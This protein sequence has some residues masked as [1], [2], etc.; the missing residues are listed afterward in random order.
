MANAFLFP[1]QGSQFIGMGKKLAESIPEAR[2]VFEEVDAAL[3]ENLSSIIWSGEL[4][5]LT[6]TK[7]AQP[8]IMAVSIAVFRSLI[9]RGLNLD[10]ISVLAGHS[11]GEYSAFC[12]SGVFSLSDTAKILRKRGLAMQKA[13]PLGKGAM[14]AILGLTSSKVSDLLKQGGFDL[15]KVQIA[16]DNDPSQVVISGEKG[17][18]EQFSEFLKDNGARKIIALPVSAPFHSFLM[19]QAAIEMEST[20]EE[21]E[22]SNPKIPI[23]LNVN[24]QTLETKEGAQQSLINQVTGTVRWRESL[25]TMNE[26]KGVN[27]FYEIGPGKVLSGT[28]K[29]TLK[30][31]N[32]FSVYELED[33][34]RM[35]EVINV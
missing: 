10:K 15:K 25:I 9:S 5:E 12:A 11:L 29:R 4:D 26:N 23:V 19:S 24:M 28:V 31:V 13:V 6:L 8:S 27:N 1:G 22:F 34:D 32:T 18:V 33:I 20:L 30:D 2:E 3:N 21:I 14:A 17:S 35:I 7:N 16:N